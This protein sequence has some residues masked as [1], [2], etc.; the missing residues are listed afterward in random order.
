V[1]MLAAGIG[2]SVGTCAF[3]L[4]RL[5]SVDRPSSLS[6]GLSLPPDHGFESW[7]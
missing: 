1:L 4:C 3:L 6:G 2:V 7:A 5:R